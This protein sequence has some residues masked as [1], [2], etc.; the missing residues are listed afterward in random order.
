MSSVSASHL[1][2]F[3]ASIVVA[4]GVAGTLVTQVDRVSQS[5]AEQSEEV[6]EQ[7]DTDIQ[8][9]SDTGSGEAI[10]DAGSGNLTLYVKNTGKSELR[11]EPDAVDV[12]VDGR[13]VAPESV[14]GVDGGTA[15]SSGEVAEIVVEDV[16]IEGATRV[17]V[18]VKESKDTILFR[19]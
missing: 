11:T 17:A 3:I 8:I 10:Y 14:I 13:F 15:W 5:I 7:I 1:V 6:E 16:E 9:I 19:A 4:A 2:I 12:L 18:T